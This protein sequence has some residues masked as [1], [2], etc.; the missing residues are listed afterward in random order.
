MIQESIYSS[1]FH[2]PLPPSYF[3]KISSSCTH[4]YYRIYTFHLPSH[5]ILHSHVH[6]TVMSMSLYINPYQEYSRM[7]ARPSLPE[8][9]AHGIN[10]DGEL[11][12]KESDDQ[13]DWR[14]FQ[15]W[16]STLTLTT[17]PSITPPSLFYAACDVG[18]TSVLSLT[19][20]LLR[21]RLRISG[22][23]ALKSTPTLSPSR[24]G[25][26]ATNIESYSLLTFALPCIPSSTSIYSPL[27]IL[28]PLTYYT[29]WRIYIYIHML[30]R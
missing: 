23:K 2:L 8:S 4:K 16:C 29:G 25:F 24:I 20:V 17:Q 15:R 14:N 11:A 18:I 1:I 9:R 12:S 30:G 5:I 19:Q 3:L 21:R 6:S 13:Y 7:L 28:L 26:C 10:I 27:C 22:A